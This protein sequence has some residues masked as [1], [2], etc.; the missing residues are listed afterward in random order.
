MDLNKYVVKINSVWNLIV[1]LT[2]LSTGGKK[3]LTRCKSLWIV[4][5]IFFMKRTL[6][7]TTYIRIMIKNFT[8]LFRHVTK[9]SSI[10]L[11]SSPL[12]VYG[13]V[14]EGIPNSYTNYVITKCILVLKWWYTPSLFLLTHM[15]ELRVTIL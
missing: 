7:N 9:I 6:R 3:F 13:K 1:Y 4:R 11:D 10:L 2:T 15:T 14:Y 12:R 5:C 8:Y